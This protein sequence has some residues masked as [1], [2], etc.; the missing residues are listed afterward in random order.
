MKAKRIWF[1]AFINMELDDGRIGRLPLVEFPRLQ[2]ATEDQRANYTL[3]PFGVHWGDI[4]EDLSYDGFL[5]SE[6]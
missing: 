5:T 6:E 4:D 2:F 1:D 3:S